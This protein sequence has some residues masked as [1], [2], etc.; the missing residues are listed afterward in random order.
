MFAPKWQLQ[1]PALV[2]PAAF[3]AVCRHRSYWHAGPKLFYTAGSD[4]ES[5]IMTQGTVQLVAGI[6]AVVL[7][8]IV[9][10]RRK[11]H[12]KKDEDEF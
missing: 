11:A 2:T 9:I 7:I 12:K 10:L 3:F 8:A 5:Q 1:P 6:L 4:A